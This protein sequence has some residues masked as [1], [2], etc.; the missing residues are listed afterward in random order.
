VR[1]CRLRRLVLAATVVGVAG[2]LSLPAFSHGDAN[3]NDTAISQVDWT[4]A[5]ETYPVPDGSQAES[6]SYDG[7]GTSDP[8][9]QD[10]SGGDGPG[11]SGDGASPGSGPKDPG[12]GGRGSSGGLLGLPFPAQAGISVGLLALAFLALLPGRKMPAD[13]R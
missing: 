1:K 8:D 4:N 2:L 6:P 10:G 3:G 5:D 9:D 7:D 11:P 12:S 13:L